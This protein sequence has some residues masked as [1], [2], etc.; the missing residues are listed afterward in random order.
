MVLTEHSA[1]ASY[2]EVVVVNLIRIH[3]VTIICDYDQAGLG[4]V[5]MFDRN[6]DIDDGSTRIPA[7]SNK[8]GDGD[9]A[10]LVHLNAQML[11]RPTQNLDLEFACT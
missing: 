9:I 5:F 8:F 10:T 7:I 3:T 2:D 1:I 4:N 11:Q 6:L